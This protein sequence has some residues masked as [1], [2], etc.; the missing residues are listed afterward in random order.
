MRHNK[1]TTILVSAIVIALSGCDKEAPFLANAPE[2]QLNCNALSVDY[3]NSNT[4]AND[5]NTGDFTVNFISTKS[6]ETIKSFIYSEMPEIVTLPAG[7]YSAE[8]V[9]GE[10]KE[11]AWDNPV[12]SG[13]SSFSIQAGKITDEIDPIECSLRN[14]KVEVDVLD[15]TGINVLGDDVKVVVSAGTG[16]LT[17]DGDHKGSIGYFDYVEGSKTISAIF[18]GTIGED[19]INLPPVLYENAAPGNAYK[20]RF[21]INRPDNV[22]DGDII[23]GEGFQVNATIEIQDENH[24]VNEDEPNEPTIIE[25]DMRP[26]DGSDDNNEDP[27]K[28][29]EEDPGNDPGT[30]PQPGFDPPTIDSDITI[31]QDH[32]SMPTGT[33]VEVDDI[34][35]LSFIVKSETGIIGFTIDIK[36]DTLK[37]DILEGVGLKTH[38]DLVNP[39]ELREGLEGLGFMTSEDVENQKE[40][41]YDISDFLPL[42]GIY[43]E[44]N[45]RFE[46]T[47]T[48][49]NGTTYAT[50]WLHNN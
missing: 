41:P 25:D 19:L 11:A 15:E 40:V 49:A 30:D 12:Y 27:G 44:A 43:G 18:S 3:I 1:Y 16:Q 22:N 13:S 46:M 26:V 37:E 33:K 32:T 14:M 35:S 6:K 4:R 48:D 34:S 42:L 38:L 9:Y 2:G 21:H 8:A 45:H 50:L 24:V 28:D 7:E 36:S 17:Y 5:V 47:I 31:D 10:S 29:P 39:G 20:I 23:V